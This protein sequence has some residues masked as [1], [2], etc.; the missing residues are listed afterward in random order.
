[1]FEAIEPPEVH[2]DSVSRQVY[3]TVMSEFGRLREG[4]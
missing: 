4:R 3:R 2:A 1:M